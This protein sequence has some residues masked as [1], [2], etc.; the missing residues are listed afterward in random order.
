MKRMFRRLLGAAGFAIVTIWSGNAAAQVVS[1]TANFCTYGAFCV[2]AWGGCFYYSW[3][4]GSGVNT[5]SEKSGIANLLKDCKTDPTRCVNL[6]SEVVLTSEPGV[7][8]VRYQCKG[9]GSDTCT[10]EG[11]GG[12]PG[13]SGNP[14]VTSIDSSI[15]VTSK[16]NEEGCVKDKAT[17][18]IK[19]TKQNTVPVL[20]D[21]V[22]ELCPNPQWTIEAWPLK[23]TGK[24]ILT[25]PVSKQS[26]SIAKS[27]LTTE[28][29]LINKD[30]PLLRPGDEGYSPNS[31]K[32]KNQMECTFVGINNE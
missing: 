15:S 23:F 4:I 14:F 25:G 31:D 10:G 3:W 26:S 19:C 17:G 32:N 28:C 6:T 16:F 13:S 30:F 24:S 9:P 18:A 21:R 2:D 29:V 22:A 7:P 27:T 12:S 11:C 20:A 1:C 8:N 5:V